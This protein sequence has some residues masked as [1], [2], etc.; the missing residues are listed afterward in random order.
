MHGYFKG[1]WITGS[2]VFV[3]V[4]IF[5]LAEWGFLI[6]IALGWIP[7]LIAGFIGGL[8]WPLIVLVICVILVV[9]LGHK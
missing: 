1:A 7:A 5:A 4:W 3:C 6:G 8:L 9:I 2:I